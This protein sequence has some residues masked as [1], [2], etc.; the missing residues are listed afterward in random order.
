M[1]DHA[2]AEHGGGV[3]DRV[4]GSGGEFDAAGFTPS[5]G[6]DLG[7]NDYR[8]TNLTDSIAGFVGTLHDAPRQNWDAV[9]SEELFGLIL[10]EVH[11]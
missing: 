8:A 11:S 1:G 6:V 2:G 9:I 4:T 5:T 10:V 3:F 7:F